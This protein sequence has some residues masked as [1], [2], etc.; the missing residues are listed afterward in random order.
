MSG[1]LSAFFIIQKEGFMDP[2]NGEMPNTE[3]ADSVTATEDQTP[4]DLEVTGEPQETEVQPEGEAQNTDDK[5]G[6]ESEPGEQPEGKKES[7]AEKRIKSLV[8]RAKRAEDE[9]A[10]YKMLA[11]KQT[12]QDQQPQ[13]QPKSNNGKEPSIDDYETWEKYQEAR[14]SYLI[15]K[16]KS[17]FKEEVKKEKETTNKE[18]AKYKFNQKL[19]SLKDS[20]PEKFDKIY[21]LPV[22]ADIV[23]EI[24]PSEN[25]LEVAEYLADNPQELQK[26]NTLTGSAV[27]RELG[28]IEARLMVPKE[29]RQTKKLSTAPEPI[30][31]ITQGKST[32][33]KP[34]EEMTVE[35][36]IQHRN[37]KDFEKRYGKRSQ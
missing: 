31:P 14:D 23:E 34:E 28:K 29:Q 7:G 32:I 5:D 37:R 35:E 8:G 16:A 13:E 4:D 36:F 24:I 15:N 6:Q 22:R 2:V 1:C 27:Y 19:S 30:T 33:K 3:T 12:Q 20:D 17:E 18:M 26:L 10:Y 25:G 21:T 9:A 11:E